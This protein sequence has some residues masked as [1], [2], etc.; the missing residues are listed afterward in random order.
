MYLYTCVFLN[1]CTPHQ[2]RL[3]RNQHESSLY[4]RMYDPRICRYVIP[5][6]FHFVR[7]CLKA[8]WNELIGTNQFFSQEVAHLELLLQPD[9]ETSYFQ[10]AVLACL[11]AID[12]K[13]HDP[14][15]T[16]MALS[17]LIN[18]RAYTFVQKPVRRYDFEFIVTLSLRCSFNQSLCI[19]RCLADVTTYG[20]VASC[21]TLHHRRSTLVLALPTYRQRVHLLTHVALGTHTITFIRLFWIYG[22]F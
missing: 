22:A 3:Q 4:K 14:D 19:V 1:T 17:S 16:I 20:I 7:L 15:V 12:S 11:P 2:S 10:R 18:S 6:W 21:A 8:Q 5:W 9:K 13:G